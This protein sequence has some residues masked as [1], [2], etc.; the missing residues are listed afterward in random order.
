V[1]PENKAPLPTYIW[2]ADWNGKKDTTSTY[3]RADGWPGR[4]LHQYRGGHDETYGGVTINIDSNVLD[5]HG[6][7]P[8]STTNVNRS[9]YRLS[10]PDIRRD[11]VVPLQCLLKKNGFY[12]GTVTGAWNTATNTAVAKFQDSVNHTGNGR[13]F[14]RSDWVSLLADGNSGALIAKGS[15]GPDVLR[16][17]RAL[18]AATSK[19]LALTGRFD[20]RTYWATISYQD[21]TGIPTTGKIG[22]TTWRFLSF[23][24][25]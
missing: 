24:K 5:L 8:C 15:T 20:D 14:S 7:P 21:A 2:I 25:W 16:A 1:N 13:L 9:T 11:L 12:P 10:T 18:N 23:G 4:R 19:Q 22:P 6:F 3:I 17:Q